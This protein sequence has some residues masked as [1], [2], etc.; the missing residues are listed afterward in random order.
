[1]SQ[2]YTAQA[3]NLAAG[4]VEQIYKY[5]ETVSTDL[6]RQIDELFDSLQSTKALVP[7]VSGQLTA[8]SEILTPKEADAEPPAQALLEY[9]VQ[10]D[11][12]GEWLLRN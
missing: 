2:A 10:L 11:E 9:F 6:Q 1:V 8:L 5:D 12:A 4:A 3:Q 7:D